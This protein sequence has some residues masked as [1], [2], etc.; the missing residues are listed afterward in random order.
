MRYVRKYVHLKEA[1]REE[2]KMKEDF[3]MK[4]LLRKTVPME[5]IKMRPQT[6]VV[7]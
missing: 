3:E 6:Y 5:I 2:E 1:E 4:V 7:R